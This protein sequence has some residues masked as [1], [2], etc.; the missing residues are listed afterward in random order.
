[1]EILFPKFVLKFQIRFFRSDMLLLI[2]YG[3]VNKISKSTRINPILKILFT[4]L[5][6]LAALQSQFISHFVIE[7]AFMCL[8]FAILLV[9][10][11]HAY[12]NKAEAQTLNRNKWN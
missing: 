3:I 2:L 10:R 4:F 12:L 8:I 9:Y 11:F 5:I 7:D 6:L 1:M